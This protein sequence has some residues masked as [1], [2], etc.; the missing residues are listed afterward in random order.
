MQG[1]AVKVGDGQ[2]AGGGGRRIG[3]KGGKEDPWVP[4]ESGTRTTDKEDSKADSRI[5]RSKGASKE[6]G[7]HWS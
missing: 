6:A 2:Y 1:N 3:G 4:K 7:R 5:P